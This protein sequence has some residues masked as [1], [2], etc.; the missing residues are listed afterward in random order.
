MTSLT[1]LV[2]RLDCCFAS[3]SFFVYARDLSTLNTLPRVHVFPQ[4]WGVVL[5]LIHPIRCIVHCVEKFPLLSRSLY[6][7]IIANGARASA[8]RRRAAESG[9]EG[10]GGGQWGRR[11]RF[12]NQMVGV[13]FIVRVLRVYYDKHGP[14]TCGLQQLCGKW[15][16]RSTLRIWY[17]PTS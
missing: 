12:N 9:R 8:F 17:D 6:I 14:P 5:V 7:Y 11:L 4:L 3:M 1:V 13:A 10:R 16:I 2:V 15:E